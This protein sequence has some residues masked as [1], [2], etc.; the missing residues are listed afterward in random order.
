M[1]SYAAAAA[2]S[3]DDEM[4]NP[5]DFLVTVALTADSNLK[6]LNASNSLQ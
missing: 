4:E 1:K 6:L 2:A 3:E 5:L